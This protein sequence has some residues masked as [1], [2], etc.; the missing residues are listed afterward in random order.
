MSKQSPPRV[1]AATKEEI[2]ARRELVFRLRSVDKLQ[3]SEIADRCGVVMETI[4]RDLRWLRNNGYDLGPEDKARSEMGK[5]MGGD[6]GVDPEEV[7]RRQNNRQKCLEL[8][9]NGMSIHGIAEELKI[10]PRTVSKY[11]TDALKAN[12]MRDVD[13]LRQLEVAR[14]DEYLEKLKPRIDKGDDKA[15]NA[16]LRVSEQR[17]RL[18]GLFTPVKIDV[19]VHEETEQDRELKELINEAKAKQAVELDKLAQQVGQ[20][21]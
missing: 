3:S 16:A 8:R 21:E 4:L 12:V 15:V 11:I 2:R 18:L 6:R 9:R 17:A 10:D 5:N 14:L 1:T 7:L 19:D 13:L 20:Q